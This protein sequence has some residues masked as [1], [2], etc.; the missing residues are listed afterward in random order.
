MHQL[1]FMG[2]QHSVLVQVG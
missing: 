1:S 2:W